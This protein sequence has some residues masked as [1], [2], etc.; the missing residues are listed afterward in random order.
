[1]TSGFPDAPR[2]D[3]LLHTHLQGGL[4]KSQRGHDVQRGVECWI[5]HRDS[6][7]DLR[8]V[9]IEDVDAE[10]ADLLDR[11]R[12]GQVALDHRRLRMNVLPSSAAEVVEQGHAIGALDIRIDDVGADEARATRYENMLSRQA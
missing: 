6:H 1:V 3:D 9:M 2:K 10:G 12:L 5:G 11:G 4:E 8:R 7:V